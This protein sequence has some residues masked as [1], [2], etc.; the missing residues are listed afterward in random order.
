M[1]RPRW[2]GAGGCSVPPLW[3][4]E[5]HPRRA[6][7]GAVQAPWGWLFTHCRCDPVVPHAHPHDVTNRRRAKKRFLLSEGTVRSPAADENGYPPANRTS[8]LVYLFDTCTYRCGYCI[9]AETGK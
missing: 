1:H 6:L 5:T 7:A 3:W 2:P 4:V 9:L 8:L